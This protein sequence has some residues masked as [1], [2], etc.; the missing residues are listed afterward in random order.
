MNRE[1][2]E[3]HGLRNELLL[4]LRT[5]PCSSSIVGGLGQQGRLLHCQQKPKGLLPLSTLL[6]G[7]PMSFISGENHI[8]RWQRCS[9]LHLALRKKHMSRSL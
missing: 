3:G 8:Q 9:R 2:M 4:T 7:T 6:T 5:S 1:L